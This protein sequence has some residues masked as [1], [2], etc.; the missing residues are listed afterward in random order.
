MNR[1]IAKSLTAQYKTLWFDKG[2]VYSSIIGFLFFLGSLVLNYGA[3][4][5]SVTK[6]GNATTDILLQILPTV[7]TDIVFSEGALLFVIFIIILLALKPKTI[8]F[9]LKSIALF[10]CIRSLFV[11]MT[12]LSPYPDHITTDLEAMSYLSSA[13]DLFF[14][15]HTGLPFL[16]A[17]LFWKNKRLKWFFLFCSAVAAIA[18]LLG[19]LHYT[20]D[21]F[22]AFFVT[23]GIFHIAQKLFAKD[24]NFFLQ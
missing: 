4:W 24:Y 6:A 10:I 23:Y 1:F 17:L 5:Y 2:F 14:S 3:V 20:I 19:H 9:T 12:H 7:N 22:A 18:V 15:G 8:P 11:I 21:V 16:M 13:N